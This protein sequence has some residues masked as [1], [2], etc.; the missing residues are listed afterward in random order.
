M[1]VTGYDLDQIAR[2]LNAAEPPLAGPSYD[3]AALKRIAR[4]WMDD[5]HDYCNVA[6]ALPALNGGQT[7][8]TLALR[9]LRRAR[10]WLRGNHGPQDRFDHLRPVDGRTVFTSLRHGPDGQG[11]LAVA[12]M[13]GK[14]LADVDPPSLIDGAGEGWTLALATP[15]LPDG[16]GGGPVTLRDSTGVVFTR[17]G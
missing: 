1:E 2:L 8:F 11:V 13:E 14:P 6:N 12:H 17:D 4:A 3:A 7:D 5:M 10:P 15:G 9:N 16:Y